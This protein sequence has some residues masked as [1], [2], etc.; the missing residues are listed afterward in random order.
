VKIILLF[1]ISSSSLAFANETIL[2]I[3]TNNNPL[4]I[5][6]ARKKAKKLGK[7]LIVYPEKGVVFTQEK[8][9]ELLETVP[10]ETL[11]LS[12]HNGGGHISGSFGS[13]SFTQVEDAMKK[14]TS[15]KE[16]TT[17]LMLLGCNT[18]NQSQIMKWKN[19]YPNLN[20]IAGY[21]G[22]APAGDKPAG[23]SFIEEIL[24]KKDDLYLQA[25]AKELKRALQS[26]KHIWFL[27]AG[28]YVKNIYCQDDENEIFDEFIFR[29]LRKDTSERFKLFDTAECREKREVDYPIIETRFRKY[30]DGEIEIDQEDLKD[31]NNFIR[32]N[33]H[34]FEVDDTREFIGGDQSLALRFWKE[35]Q[36]NISKYYAKDIADMFKEINILQNLDVQELKDNK[37]KELQLHLKSNN[38]FLSSIENDDIQKE[39]R[40][41]IKKLDEEYE[42]LFDRSNVIFEKLNDIYALIDNSNFEPGIQSI[43]RQALAGGAFFSESSLMIALQ[44]QYPE[45]FLKADTLHKELM[46]KIIAPYKAL[47]PE[48]NKVQNKLYSSNRKLS[49]SKNLLKTIEHPELKQQL[50]DV[51]KEKS[52]KIEKHITKVNKLDVS[53]IKEQVSK[54]VAKTPEEYSTLGRKNMSLFAHQLTGILHETIDVIPHHNH[55]NLHSFNQGLV[56]NIS[57]NLNDN[58]MPFDWHEIKEEVPVPSHFG[59]YEFRHY[60]R[61]EINTNSETN[62]N[63]SLYS[64]AINISENPLLIDALYGRFP[65]E[66]PSTQSGFNPNVGGF[67]F[68]FYNSDP[69]SQ[70]ARNAQWN[71]AINNQGM[72]GGMWGGGTSSSPI[73]REESRQFNDMQTPTTFGFDFS[74]T[75]SIPAEQAPQ[76]ESV[77]EELPQI[78]L[79]D[80]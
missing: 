57:Y 1:L 58:Y 48:F 18:S 16:N 72:S 43:A 12:G 39:L 79:R 24:E 27:E 20:I 25:S 19:I 42:I 10:F 62:T 46:K 47:L 2:F 4:E 54:L 66:D 37:L 40:S 11:I 70:N 61:D 44:G 38:T 15:A 71:N 68:G 31:I 36:H 64:Q 8:A 33:N 52:K 35:T 29:P 17:T 22:T 77:E 67:G 80:E 73:T 60:H 49:E 45:D 30:I 78:R 26:L 23:H 28:I 55:L 3:D 41:E 21:D 34:C 65:G 69:A 51:L 9:Q 5:K 56:Q 14:N 53:Y 74:N 76:R 50:L 63:F 59:K 7:K 6:T 75:N 32:R 13:V